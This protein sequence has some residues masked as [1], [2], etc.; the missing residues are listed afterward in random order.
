MKPENII[1]TD[2]LTDTGDTLPGGRHTIRI[3]EHEGSLLAVK[4]MDTSEAITE[5]LAYDVL[6]AL[7]INTPEAFLVQTDDLTY[8]IAT[9]YEKK[10]HKVDIIQTSDLMTQNTIN[11]L[12]TQNY[13]IIIGIYKLLLNFQLKQSGL[14]YTQEEDNILLRPIDPE[15]NTQQSYS[16][17]SLK[18][19]LFHLFEDP[20]LESLPLQ[21]YLMMYLDDLCITQ[22]TATKLKEIFETLAKLDEEKLQSIVDQYST[23]EALCKHVPDDFVTS[24][25]QRLTKLQEIKDQH[26]PNCSDEEVDTFKSTIQQQIEEENREKKERQRKQSAQRMARIERTERDGRRPRRRR[27]R[28]PSL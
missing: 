2:E 26:F 9:S 21:N 11:K 28:G 8:W 5:M 20:R 16:Q 3:M 15:I 7:G 10:Y 27:R 13:H 17:D 23:H 18:K 1:T 14:L 4:E 24:L 12:P 25:N 19:T 6:K 22:M